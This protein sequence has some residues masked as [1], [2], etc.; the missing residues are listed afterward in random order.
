MRGRQVWHNP[1]MEPDALQAV[2]SLRSS[3][4][5]HMLLEG[6]RRWAARYVWDRRAGRLVFP[7]PADAVELA[8]GQ[9]LVPDEHDP[10]VAALLAIEQP[11]SIDG[12]MEIRFEIY[13]G[14]PESAR[15]GLA[16]IEA[17]RHHGATFDADE[18]TL[19]DALVAD[20]PALCRELNADRERL[21]RLCEAGAGAAVESPVAVG[22]DPDGIDVRAR[23][24]IIRIGFEGRAETAEAV[25]ER[26]A[27]MAAA[28]RT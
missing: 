25:R 16:T 23:F 24:G 12:A 21:A 28:G 11:D 27:Q 3:A 7:L 20:E 26:V 15:W 9:L 17:L 13:H 2:K 14:R 10:A 4:R 19:T 18:L 8:E 1:A 6:P 5:G 22:V